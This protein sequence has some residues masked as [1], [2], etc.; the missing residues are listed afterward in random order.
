MAS[1]AKVQRPGRTTPRQLLGIE[2]VVKRIAARHRSSVHYLVKTAGF[3][4]PIPLGVRMRRWDEQEV[5]AWLERR[6]AKRTATKVAAP[7]AAE[8]EPAD[9]AGDQA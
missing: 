7:A 4:P 9:A 2:Q 5:D 3:P 6:A 1:K 8:A